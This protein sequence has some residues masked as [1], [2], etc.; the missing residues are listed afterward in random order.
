MFVCLVGWS[1]FSPVVCLIENKTEAG[2]MFFLP[3]FVIR[4]FCNLKKSGNIMLSI[5]TES[6]IISYHKYTG[7]VGQPLYSIKCSSE[8]FP[9]HQYYLACRTRVQRLTPRLGWDAV[10]C[11]LDSIFFLWWNIEPYDWTKSNNRVTDQ[12][13][14]CSPIKWIASMIR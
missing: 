13:V 14:L 8:L 2:M 3:K 4:C 6:P 11:K 9:K 1:F 12:R 7:H 5:R 10:G